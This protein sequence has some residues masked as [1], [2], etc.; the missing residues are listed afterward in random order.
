[1]N[2]VFEN[3]IVDY[4]NLAKQGLKLNKSYLWMLNTYNDLNLAPDISTEFK[5]SVFQLIDAIQSE[6]DKILNDL[7]QLS[8][9]IELIT[10]TVTELELDRKLANITQDLPIMS[11]F[12]S[13]IDIIEL[14]NMF[15]NLKTNN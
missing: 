11:D 1:M 14:R 3:A 4:E 5:E 9:Q 6:Q 15:I 13:S 10:Q 12:V 7:S 8:K 2:L